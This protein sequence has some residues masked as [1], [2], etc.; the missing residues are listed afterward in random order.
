VGQDGGWWPAKRFIGVDSTTK[1]SKLTFS[2]PM[3]TLVGEIPVLL[4]HDST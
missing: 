3:R 2:R 1:L 4:L